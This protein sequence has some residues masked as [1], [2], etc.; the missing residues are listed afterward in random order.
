M[1]K[2][3]KVPPDGSEEEKAIGGVLTFSQ[4]FWLIGGAVLG[5]ILYLGSYAIIGLQFISIPL[6]LAGVITGVPFAFKKKNGI[7]YY[8]YLKRKRVFNK[9]TKQLINRRK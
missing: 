1:S 7:T 2:V 6:G 3:Y 5:L 4:F 9:K 8:C